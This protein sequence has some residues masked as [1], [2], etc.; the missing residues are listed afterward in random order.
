MLRLPLCLRPAG[1][2]RLQSRGDPPDGRPQTREEGRGLKWQSG[3][4]DAIAH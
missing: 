2:A 4:A 3:W 1:A